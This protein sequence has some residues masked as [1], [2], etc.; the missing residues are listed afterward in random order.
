[1]KNFKTVVSMV[2]VFLIAILLPSS[3]LAVSDYDKD[4]YGDTDVVIHVPITTLGPSTSRSAIARVPIATDSKSAGILYCSII[5]QGFDNRCEVIISWNTTF[6]LKNI[7]FKKIVLKSPSILNSVTYKTFGN[8][9]KY[10]EYAADV[11][12]MTGAITIGYCDTIPEDVDSV[13]VTSSSMQV[14]D[15]SSGWRSVVELSGLVAVS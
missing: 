6:L 11:A 15:M 3:A 8:G 10:S 7:R 2:L 12:A 1:M 13:K 5:R 14:Y 4:V 9:L